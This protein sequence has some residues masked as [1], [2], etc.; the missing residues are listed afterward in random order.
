MAFGKFSRKTKTKHWQKQMLKTNF[1][2]A[3]RTNVLLAQRFIAILHKHTDFSLSSY[4]VFSLF[5]RTAFVE[6]IVP[7]SVCRLFSC[8]VFISFFYTVSGFYW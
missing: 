3:C 5:L 2:S 7:V 4:R 6:I 8:D 1:Y